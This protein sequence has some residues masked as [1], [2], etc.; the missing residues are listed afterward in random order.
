MT[1]AFRRCQR[2]LEDSWP[3]GG[4]VRQRIER[5]CAEAVKRLVLRVARLVD[6]ATDFHAVLAFVEQQRR[7]VGGFEHR[8]VALRKQRGAAAELQRAESLRAVGQIA[9]HLHATEWQ[10]D[11]R[12]SGAIVDFET[13]AQFIHH[14]RT[15]AR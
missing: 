3:V 1:A 15:K 12:R 9:E 13:G 8:V 10:R 7:F 6:Q 5:E 2:A 11:E 14:R 4:K